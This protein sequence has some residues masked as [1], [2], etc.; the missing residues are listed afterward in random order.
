MFTA[1]TSARLFDGFSDRE[2]AVMG[3]LLER[4]AAA[5]V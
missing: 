5:A 4:L 1:Q 2:L 3:R